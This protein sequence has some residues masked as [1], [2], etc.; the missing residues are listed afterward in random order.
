[1][2]PV[3]PVLLWA[4]NT[5][6]AGETGI[7]R[8]V[9]ELTK[10]LF[11]RPRRL[12]YELCAPAGGEPTWLP[13]G[14]SVRRVKGPRRV[15]HGAWTVA[16]W[17]PIERL[18]GNAALVHALHPAFPV[19]TRSPFVLTLHDVFPITNPEWYRPRVLP[20][21]RR[22]LARA[23]Q[24]AV[25]LVAV[26]SETARA[27]EECFPGLRGRITVIPNGIS[28]RFRVHVP[29]DEVTAACAGIGVERGRY[30]MALGGVVSRKNLPLLVRALARSRSGLRLV[31]VGPDGN[32]VAALDAALDD[33]GM[34]ERVV[35]L[36]WLPTDQVVALLAGAAA[37]GHAAEAEG[38]GFTPL[39]AMAVGTPAIVS[40]SA[41]LDEIVGDHAVLLP[42]DPDQWAAAFDRAATDESWRS[43]AVAAGRLW[44]STFTWERT[45]DATA[46]LH[47]E[48]LEA[49]R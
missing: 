6:A 44:A 2:S 16:G 34:R 8:Y 45:A 5:D 27:A 30:V 3:E 28:D 41:A 1:V 25:A 47:D 29:N 21:F 31:I 13:E 24:T 26:S 46:A 12:D 32:G 9:R 35:R 22:A 40:Q 10:A 23:E 11:G 18:A 42:P 19:P 4:L 37:L 15:V 43:Q 49:R 36:G 33:E 14:R 17:P 39:E 38:F 48:V 7:G 20:G